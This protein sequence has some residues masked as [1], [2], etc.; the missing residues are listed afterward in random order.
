M[1]YEFATHDFYSIEWGLSL[2]TSAPCKLVVKFKIMVEAILAASELARISALL[3]A[4]VAT[5]YTECR[6]LLLVSPL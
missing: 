6:L 3:R 4:T 2:G 5:R 1:A